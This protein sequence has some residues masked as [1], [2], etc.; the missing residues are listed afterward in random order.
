MHG[1][2]CPTTHICVNL[3]ELHA[4]KWGTSK[5]RDKITHPQ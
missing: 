4:C 5:A 1:C 2:E 3:S